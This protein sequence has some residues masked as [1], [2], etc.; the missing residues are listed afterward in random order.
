MVR[1]IALALTVLTGF[2][3]LVYQVAWQKYLAALLGSQS[4]ATAA[5]LGLF[6]GGLSFGYF[7]YGKVSTSLM[8]KAR[9]EEKPPRLLFTYGLVEAGIGVWALLFPW[10]F[11]AV[12]A[13][14]LWLPHTTPAA[15]FAIDVLL[16]ALLIL[17]PT[18]LMGGT[19]PLLTQ[20]LSK[21][22]EDATRF[23][24]FVYAFNTIGAFAGALAAGFF[25]VPWIGLKGSVLAM[26]LVNLAAGLTF[27]A[28]GKRAQA[29]IPLAVDSEVGPELIHGFTSYAF[30]ALLAGFSMMTLQT[31]MNRIGALALGA[32]HFTFSMIVATF[33]L[34]IAL[35]SFAVSALPRIRPSYLVFSQWALVA[36]LIGL[37]KV[38]DDSSYWAYVLRLQFTNAPESFQ[39]YYFA[40]F[41]AILAIF[42]LPLALSGATLPLLFHHLRHQV[43]DLGSVAGRL[44]SWNTVGS[45]LG[46]L[47]GGY[48]L[49]FWLDLHHIYRIAVLGLALGAAILTARI[50]EGRKLVAVATLATLTLVLVAL[51]AWPPKKMHAG[52]FREKRTFE[53]SFGGPAEF[54]KNFR[55]TWPDDFIVFAD[56]DATASIAVFARKLPPLTRG[57]PES[58]ARAIITNGKGDSEIPL[59]NPTMVLAVALPALLTEQRDNAFIVGYGT[60]MSVG[61]LASIPSVERVVVAEFAQG[62]IDA[63]PLFDPY[64]FGASVNPKVEIIHSD[65]YRALLRSDAVFDLIVSEP[66]NPWVTGVEML[67]SKEFLTAARSRLAPKGIHVQWMHAY[68]T[69]DA[70]LELVMRSYLEVYEKVA[71]WYIDIYD[72]LILGFNDPETEIDLDL[73]SKRWEK[74]E[75]RRLFDLIGIDSLPQLFAHELLP[76]G[77][78]Q[79]GDLP[80]P[81]HTIEH[82]RLADAAARAFFAR[83]H[84][85]FPNSISNRSAMSG[86]ENSLYRRYTARRAQPYSER[87][88]SGLVREICQTFRTLCPTAF[89][90]W[91]HARP[92]DSPH[93]DEMSQEIRFEKLH[94]RGSFT[95]I[96]PGLIDRLAALYEPKGIS[97]LPPTFE[98][99]ALILELFTRHYDHAAPF[100]PASLIRAWEKCAWDERCAAR[101]DEVRNTGLPSN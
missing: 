44:Y 93:I 18:V 66:S 40:V 84:G 54:F 16:A 43:G 91:K 75:Y 3:G 56:D 99:A 51:P 5:V 7:L 67:Y 9:A 15:A 21:G 94:E 82:P 10:L 14:S 35:G 78:L 95:G 97:G 48:A 60:G 11:K 22:L 26:G 42:L 72:H 36:Y 101:L 98:S 32:S 39:P 23:H 49:F 6:L 96:P 100:D 12:Q 37:Y 87:E 38:I 89:A 74:E 64:N 30:V 59:D 46:A 20:G 41:L 25:L 77:V 69:D 92:E 53:F 81:I 45:L 52:L 33:V 27:V 58:D 55:N 62:V 29:P 79:R 47:I 68:E 80:G 63:A 57:G 61:A 31:A 73:V 8:D 28:L 90:R 17:P 24:S 70:T 83:G 19:I 65:A 50:F 86:S 34:C 2:S 13:I 71:V 85:T 4:E 1:G 88:W 76:T